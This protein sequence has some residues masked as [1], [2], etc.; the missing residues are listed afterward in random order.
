M[1]NGAI[2]V[3]QGEHGELQHLFDRVSSPDEDR[4]KVL[5]AL[6]QRMAAHVDMEKELLFPVLRERVEGGGS[7][8]DRLR[9]G[10]GS[11]EHT[12]TLLERRK[13]NSPDV[14]DLVTDLLGAFSDHVTY[15]DET[16]LPGLAVLSEPE[17]AELGQAMAS[18]ERRKLTHAHPAVPDSGPLASVARKAAE[19]VDR[20]RD[21]STNVGRTSS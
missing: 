2:E 20:A 10:H 4:P 15:A 21:R 6:M 9:E 3:L 16:V 18:E 14:A 12:L 17:L 19:L 5:E 1:S 7:V 8:V 13:A 11:V